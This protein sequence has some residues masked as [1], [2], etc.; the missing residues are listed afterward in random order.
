MKRF[1]LLAGLLCAFLMYGC[2][3]DYKIQIPSHRTEYGKILK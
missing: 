3:L 2:S 1:K